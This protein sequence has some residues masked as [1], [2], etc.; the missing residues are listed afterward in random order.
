MRGLHDRPSN[1]VL[2]GVTTASLI[3]TSAVTLRAWAEP[4]ALPISLPN[5]Q[6]N[7]DRLA[8]GTTS[9]ST[10]FEVDATTST[11][12]L[13]VTASREGVTVGIET[14]SGVLLTESDVGSVGGVYQQIT[15]GVQNGGFLMMLANQPGFHQL[16]ELPSQ[17]V[18]TYTIHL[19][20]PPGMTDDV[21]VIT[22]VLLDG[23]LGVSFFAADPV[24]PLGR[25]VVLHAAVFDGGSPVEGVSS[26]VF[27]KAPSGTEAFPT[28]TDDGFGVPDFAAGDGLYSGLFTPLEAGTHRAIVDVS[29]TTSGGEAFFRRAGTTFQVVEPCATLTG[30][31]FDFG[32][33]DDGDG[34][35]ERLVIEA[36]VNVAADASLSVLI[37]LETATGKLMVAQ[38][39]ADLSAGSGFVATSID[40]STVWNTGEDGPYTIKTLELFCRGADG[41]VLVD[42][43]LDR[44][45]FTQPYLR[46]EFQRPSLR[47]TGGV[48]EQT[49]DLEPDGDFDTLSVTVGVE[50]TVGGDYSFTA[51]LIAPCGHEIDS[52][53]GSASIPPFP[54]SGTVT[55]DF[56]GASIGSSGLDGPYTIAGL[57]VWNR[58]ASLYRG[59]VTD[60]QAY[61]ASEFDSF[62]TAPDC[63]G[64]LIP[65][66]CDVA[67]GERPD[68][69]RNGV[70]VECDITLGTD[71]DCNGDTIPD[72]CDIAL[73]LADDTNSNEVPDVCEVNPPLPA[74]YPHDRPKNRYLSFDPNKIANDGRNT[75]FRVTLRALE[76][77]SCDGN[78]A[79]CRVDTGGK[80]EPGDADCN[81]CS[82]TG[83]PCI[84][85]TTDCDPEPPQSCDSTGQRCVNDRTTSGLSNVG[86]VWWVG[87]ESP[88]ANGVHLMVSESFRKVST[89]WPAVVHVG[90]CEI[91]PLAT[92]GIAAVDTDN[93]VISAERI[94][95]T[96]DRP[97]DSASWWADAVG[98]LTR[99]CNGDLREPGCGQPG[100]PLCPS[101][102][103]C[104]LV[105][106]LP[107]GIVNFD[108]V[109]A[110]LAV[111]A[112]GP[113]STAADLTWVD[114][115]GNDS[116]NPLSEQFDPPN[117]IANFSDVA[118]VLQG[119][120]GRPYPFS[121]PG[122]CPDVS[123]WP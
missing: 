62:T 3:L 75:A 1:G 26:S 40:A 76:L 49:V 88:L 81:A 17:G 92:Y 14:P 60:T 47:L 105:W 28:L 32:E 67:S 121:D 107:D 42:R 110:V 79:P 10:L 83:N 111:L 27:V 11:M 15:G 89:D 38:G 43:D 61:S 109:N 55:L 80:N 95:R 120:A 58:A 104:S 4:L 66:T 19:D 116:G 103:P 22:S 77:G 117:Y 73:G 50:A 82:I 30:G 96:I 87:P 102:Q 57:G 71:R 48:G 53:A 36:D 112:P 46:T 68:C 34:F 45:D 24:V 106:G 12:F 37:T 94:V 64:N 118:A 101:G 9:G 65:D 93:G 7:L 78:G 33:D 108:D 84:E 74:P 119:F 25:P 44:F 51:R 114:M 39:A 115:H 35:F 23:S 113:K 16:I 29:G 122:D 63:N 98:A 18:G 69:D 59:I 21:A 13:L 90:D 20:A 8:P 100:D 31:V 85:Q 99:H 2:V 54:G 6:V 72:V 91:V 52:V 5:M 56:D 97:Y 70:P 123:T 41:P 86:M